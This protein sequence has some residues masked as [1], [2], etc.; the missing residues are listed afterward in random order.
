M[1]LGVPGVAQAVVEAR[2]E[3]A[4]LGSV[5]LVAYYSVH[6]S[7]VHRGPA[8]PDPASIYAHLRDQLPSYMIPDFLEQLDV[9]PSGKADR[10]ALPPPSGPRRLSGTRGHVPPESAAEQELAELLADVLG[11]SEVSVVSDFFADLGADS[12]LMA[13]FNAAVRRRPGWSALSMRHVYSYPTIRQ[14]AAALGQ[15]EPAARATPRSG[16]DLPDRRT[17]G[18]PRYALFGLLQIAAFANCA[19]AYAWV[20]DLCAGWVLAAHGAV[21]GEQVAVQTA[22]AGNPAAGRLP[23]YPGY[24]TQ[25]G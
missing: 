9:L 13:R 12:L 6:R 1:L 14:L 10:K 8:A 15:R 2:P 24:G 3:A 20:L 7:P 22:W 18:K 5:R 19:L 21:E 4:G 23:G 16:T 17:M 25:L 11:V